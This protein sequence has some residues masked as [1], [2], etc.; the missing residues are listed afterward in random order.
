MPTVLQP[1]LWRT[2]DSIEINGTV[3]IYEG[4][5]DREAP[6]LYRRKVGNEGAPEVDIAV[7]PLEGTIIC[8]MGTAGA[9]TTIAP[10][11]RWFSPCSRH[12]HGQDRR[13]TGGLRLHRHHR[14]AQGKSQTGSGGQNCYI[15]D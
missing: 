14:A 1:R 2:L 4:E 9:I 12:V 13:R 15:E 7:D 11:S 8:A 3:V 10:A 5:M 6:M